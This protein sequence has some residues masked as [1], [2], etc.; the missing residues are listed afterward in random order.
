V[1][2]GTGVLD[3]GGAGVRVGVV[4]TMGVGVGVGEGVVL[5][6][7]T[8]V[9]LVTMAVGVVGLV[10]LEPSSHA[11]TTRPKRTNAVIRV[12]PHAGATAIPRANRRFATAEP[13]SLADKADVTRRSG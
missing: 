4:P 3:A 1:G 9:S 13:R 2:L 11:L 7:G 10:T 12:I 5:T 6:G 8:N